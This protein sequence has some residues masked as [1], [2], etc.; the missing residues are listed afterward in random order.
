MWGLR[1]V[2]SFGH[3]TIAHRRRLDKG[4]TASRVDAVIRGSEKRGGTG[5]MD[6]EM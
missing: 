1:F 6:L 5:G 4:T 2:L 3:L